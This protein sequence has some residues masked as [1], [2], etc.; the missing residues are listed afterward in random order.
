LY[1]LQKGPGSEHLA[2][3][4]ARASIVDLADR[5]QDFD[6][7]AAVMKNLDLVVSCDSAPVHLAGALGVRVWMP[8]P[9]TPDWRWLLDREDSPWYPTMR[10]FRQLPDG[11]WEPVFQRLAAE[12]AQLVA[13]AG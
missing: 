10:V 12:L 13:G 9:Y 11:N 8:L 3:L 4:A 5:I 7:A 1:S 2:G 6:D